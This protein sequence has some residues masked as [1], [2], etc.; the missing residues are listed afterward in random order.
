MAEH[1]DQTFQNKTA[2]A[3]A[4]INRKNN[5]VQLRDNRESS[6][7]QKKLSQNTTNQESGFTLI[8]RKKN[9]TGLPDNLKSGIENLS[10]HSMDD[11]KVHYNS[12]KPTQLNAH[13]YA[14]G[15]DIHIA[16]GQEKH[17]PHEAWHVVQ[18]KQGRVKPTLQ[19]KGKINVNDDKGLEKEADVMGA[20]ALQKQCKNEQLQL[21]SASSF[22]NQSFQLKQETSL[23]P[24]KLNMIGETHTDYPNIK[25]RRYEAKQIRDVLGKGYQYYTENKLKINSHDEDYADPV[26]QRL[27]QS[28]AFVKSDSADVITKLKEIDIDKLKLGIQKSEKQ[29][30]AEKEKKDTVD[31]SSTVNEFA[32]KIGKD[33]FDFETIK[34]ELNVTDEEKYSKDMLKKLFDV[35]N[36]KYEEFNPDYKYNDNFN[37]IIDLFYEEY[38]RRDELEAS[39]DSD[40]DVPDED[41]ANLIHSRALLYDTIGFYDK[42]KGRLPSTLKLYY[43]LKKSSIYD[44]KTHFKFALK[45]VPTVLNK[46]QELEILIPVIKDALSKN[47]DVKFPQL[48]PKALQNLEY[49]V[50]ALAQGITGGLG[51]VDIMSAKEKRSIA[52]NNAANKIENQP[53]AWK[54]GNLHIEDIIELEKKHTMP[55][56]RYTYITKNDFKNQYIDPEKMKSHEGDDNDLGEGYVKASKEVKEKIIKADKR[57]ANRFPGEDEMDTIKVLDLSNIITN[58][59]AIIVDAI[60]KGV[61]PSLKTLKITSKSMTPDLLGRLKSKGINVVLT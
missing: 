61:L 53:I 16:S 33:N 10:G 7:I 22:A 54:V 32:P 39:D 47:E 12:D 35:D 21:K 9:N 5:A 23:T 31:I 27:E 3:A 1:H 24:G 6:A 14:Q 4:N 19:M 8:Q 46:W 2:V 28:I 60:E 44:G 18:Q 45:M 43:E 56:A 55:P 11:V 42:H 36:W 49:I 29:K 59:T 25:A 20:K 40:E 17:L 38:N 15:S 13:A 41:N 58:Q 48:I 50:H 30:N 52:M 26:D 57:L 51:A 37:A 34:T